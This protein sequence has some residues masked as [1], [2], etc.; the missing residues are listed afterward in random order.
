MKTGKLDSELLKKIVF[1]HIEYK[2]KDVLVRPGI[3]KDCAIV[4]Y[5]EN[6]C[7]LSTDPITGATNEVGRLA[8][9]ISCNDIASEGLEPLGIMLA[10]M[11]P[12]GT[13]ESEIDDIMKQAGEEA[14]KLKVEIIGGH[15][16]ITN[17]VNKTIIVSTAIGKVSKERYENRDDVKFGDAVIL[18]K[19]AGL[20]GTGIIAYDNEKALFEVLTPEEIHNA[21]AMLEDVSVIREGVIAG[22]IGVSSMHDV[23]EGGILGAIWE[24]CE[25]SKVGAT[26]YFDK[27]PVAKET[28]KIC[29]FYDLDYLKLIS[30]GCMIITVSE[31]KKDKLLKALK[32]EG[33]LATEIGVIQEKAIQL[34]KDGEILEIEPPE[35][36]ELYKV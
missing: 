8:V 23:T 24:I 33:I 6:V 5:G 2:S 27:I 28:L 14:E 21:K 29:N 26:V 16:E 19:L 34:I 10:I 13:T 11:V 32:G 35:S 12:E 15:T 36:D 3:G 22:D 31:K 17:A 7:V 20:E 30:S 18:T 4:D 9:H 1:E 25:S